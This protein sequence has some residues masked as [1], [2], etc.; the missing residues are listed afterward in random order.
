MK[1]LFKSAIKL[2]LEMILLIMPCDKKKILIVDGTPYSGSNA[3]ALYK[4]LTKKVGQ[5]YKVEIFFDDNSNI[6][7]KIKKIAEIKRSGI[8]FSTHLSVPL[9]KRRKQLVVELWHGIPLKAMGLIDR[10]L[11]KCNKK[12]YAYVANKP[13]II[14]STSVFYNTIINACYGCYKNPYVITGLPRNDFLFEKGRLNEIVP[15]IHNYKWKILFSPTFRLGYENRVEGLKRE[16]NLFG[17]DRFDHDGFL[18]FLRKHKILFIAKL[19][20]FE[21]RY[22]K[23]LYENKENHN[24]F[25]LSNQILREKRIDLYEI[26]PDIDL[27]ITDYSSIYFDYLLLDR[28][29]IFVCN[30]LEKYRKI[31]GLLLEPYDFWT[32]S[33]KVTSQE[34]LQKELERVILK[35][36]DNYREQRKIIRDIVHKYQDGK[37]CE[38]IY[39]FVLKKYI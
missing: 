21:E 15:Q 19:H 27:L 38:R 33:P 23:A 8:I 30:D 2:F 16:S 20:P 26:L 5:N 12:L 14:I 1:M 31:R 10:S 11:G 17:F 39:E 25:F 36:G 22:Y 13:D 9:I 37:S 34:Q 28:P 4:Y 7:S 35:K 29:M 18:D 32:P 3:Y 6:L 24:M